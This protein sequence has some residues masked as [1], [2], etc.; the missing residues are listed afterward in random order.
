[1]GIFSNAQGQLTLQPVVGFGPISN[2]SELLC[3]LSF[4]ACMEKIQ[5]KIAEIMRGQCSLHTKS[6]GAVCC[7]ENQSSELTWH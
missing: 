7:H 1:M 2:S 5:L 4:L 3:M 6:M